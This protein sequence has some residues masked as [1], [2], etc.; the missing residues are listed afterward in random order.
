VEGLQALVDNNKELV[1]DT[2]TGSGE[3]NQQAN[4]LYFTA[5]QLMDIIKGV[6]RPEEGEDL[7]L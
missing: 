5:N 1:R 7:D 6:N 3:L 2:K 4:E